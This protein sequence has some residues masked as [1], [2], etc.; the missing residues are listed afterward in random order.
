MLTDKATELLQD[1]YVKYEEFLNRIDEGLL[2]KEELQQLLHNDEKEIR[3][4]FES[5]S[6]ELKFWRNVEKNRTLWK[7]E[8]RPGSRPALATA[9]EKNEINEKLSAITKILERNSKDVLR[10]EIVFSAQ[11]QYSAKMYLFKILK[12]AKEKVTIVDEYLDET[13]FPYLESLNSEV[14]ITLITFKLN[15]AFK[16]LLKSYILV[17][18]GVIA[19]QA[20]YTESSHSRYI[21]IDDKYYY[22]LGASMNAADGSIMKSFSIQ[23]MDEEAA[24]DE[25]RSNLAQWMASG[26]DVN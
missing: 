22:H 18:P 2:Y 10:N 6:D 4:I 15:S 7:S 19:K 20:N 24:K 14:Q 1:T 21:I 26:V 13:L 16:S 11:Q 9:E 17:R 5:D 12:S 8:P 25:V 23:R 3:A